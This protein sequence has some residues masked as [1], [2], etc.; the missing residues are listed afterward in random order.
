MRIS[1]LCIGETH[2][3]ELKKLNTEYLRRLNFYSRVDF[4]EIP[5]IK[6]AKDLQMDELK[7]KEWAEISRKI[8]R[9]A[10]IV[11]L[12]EKGSEYTSREFSGFIQKQQLNSVKDL[13]FIIG[14]A[15][16]FHQEACKVAKSK[17]ALSKMTFS[18][19]MV[20]VIFLEQL[21]RGFTIIKGEK[22]HH[23]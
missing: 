5:D 20:R 12:D 19:Q 8:P 13:V 10:H 11:L 22:Y 21:Y 17:M 9:M 15:F 4:I 6:N 1:V 7:K 3:P 18:H 23:D 2:L 14:G 16:G